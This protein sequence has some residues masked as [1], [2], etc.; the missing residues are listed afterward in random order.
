VIEFHVETV[1]LE[2]TFY[3][4]LE[5]VVEALVLADVFLVVGL[6]VLFDCIAFELDA[7]VDFVHTQGVF[8]VGLGVGPSQV[9]LF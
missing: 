9:L 6:E 7:V 3:H 8:E 2:V 4:F 5:E 1:L